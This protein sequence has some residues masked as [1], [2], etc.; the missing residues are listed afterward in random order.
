M[1]DY[2]V[3]ARGHVRR[4]G[5]LVAVDRLDFIVEKREEELLDFAGLTFSL[6]ILIM[7][8]KAHQS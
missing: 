7:R 3:E 4:Y 6:S 1:A 2:V 8:K 5:D